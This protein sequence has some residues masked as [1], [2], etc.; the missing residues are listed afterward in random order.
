LNVSN[1]NIPNSRKN[2]EISAKSGTALSESPNNNTEINNS[3]NFDYTMHPAVDAGNAMKLRQKDIVDQDKQCRFMARNGRY[4]VKHKG[5]AKR[6][7]RYVNDFFTTFV[8]M[9]WRYT[10]LSFALF[11]IVSWLFFAGCYYLIESV[12]FH[13][14]DTQYKNELENTNTT[15]EDSVFT[16]PSYGYCVSEVTKENLFTGMFLFSLET[17]TTIGYGYRAITAECPEAILLL[18][19]QSVVGCL[20]DAFTA[21]YIIAKFSRPKKRAATLLFSKHAVICQRDGKLCL[22]FRVGNLR[23][24]L[25]V[26]ATIRMLYIAERRTN[27]KEYIPLEQRSMTLDLGGDSEKILLVTPQIVCHPIDQESPLYELSQS[28]LEHLSSNSDATKLK[29]DEDPFERFEIIV[30]LEGQVESTGMT[31]QARV[32]YVAN[33]IKWGCRFQNILDPNGQRSGYKVNFQH[34]NMISQ[35]R[36]KDPR[37]AKEIEE[38]WQ[39]EGQNMED[40]DDVSELPESELRRRNNIIPEEQEHS[41]IEEECSMTLMD[42]PICEEPLNYSTSKIKQ[43]AI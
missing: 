36:L 13:R 24:S 40:E 29:K 42:E 35:C 27:E 20:I 6:H 31:M 11:F 34:F 39:E 14:R 32:S 38:E 41:E 15:R 4:L 5:K 8:D 25:L 22:M 28:K 9:K 26:E 18:I 3:E 37:S 16:E 33:E 12:R 10:L 19:I 23:K 43:K 7:Q 17:Q 21:G 1:Q 2:S 30:V